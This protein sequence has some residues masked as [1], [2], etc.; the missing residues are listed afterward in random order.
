MTLYSVLLALSTAALFFA[1]LAAIS[2]AR[3][4]PLRLHPDNPHYFLFRGRPTLLITSGEHYGAVLNA[5]FDYRRYLDALAADGLNNTRLFVG[6]YCEPA[7]AFNI[8]RNTLAPEAGRF[9]C[10]WARS[11]QP[12]YANG[13]NKFD[14]SRWDQAYF[15]RLKDFVQQAAERAI[16]VEVNLFCPFYQ[17]D[18]W[19]LSPM[20]GRNNVNNLGDVPREKVYT[21]DGHG[22]LLA[23]QENLVRKVAEELQGADNLYYEIMNEPYARDVPMAWQRRM[24]DVLVAAERRLGRRHLISLNIANRKAKVEDLH[25]DVSLL[26]FHYAWPPETVAMNYAL[27]RAIGDNETGFKST[28]DF[29]YRREGW[30]FILAG[31]ALYNNLDY[32]FA[33]GHERGTFA[34]PSTQPGG[35]TAA[36]RAQLRVLG[37][38]IRGFD[39]IRMAP[40]PHLVGDLPQGVAAYALAQAGKQYALYICRTADELPVEETRLELL[41]DLPQGA[42]RAEWLNASTGAVA[43]AESFA[44]QGGQR[45]FASPA[46]AEDLA[47]RV[48][49]AG[50]DFRR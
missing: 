9:L 6:A 26:N 34:Y 39:F 27:N 10:P 4:E 8:A 5:D 46:F 28:R 32:S 14:L 48:L 13:G 30:A 44:H 1:L 40:A 15:A 49:V 36:L 11:D 22:G 2:P 23:V 47:L 25:P 42:Y 20:N 12:G 50:S 29:F 45:T 38:F 16:V 24:I 21:L 43:R 17:D 37:Q 35:G 33:V 3:A 31:G 18:M 19:H 7:G 41:L